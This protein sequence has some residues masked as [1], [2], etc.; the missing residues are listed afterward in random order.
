VHDMLG[1]EIV[2][3]LKTVFNYFTHEL[4]RVHAFVLHHVF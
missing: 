1:V 3:P 4:T 2:Q